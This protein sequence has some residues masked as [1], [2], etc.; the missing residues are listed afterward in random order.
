MLSQRI[1][2]ILTSIANDTY[3]GLIKPFRLEVHAKEM[4]TRHGDYTP[5]T[6]VMRIFNLSR[7]TT[8]I[9]TTSIH[10]LAHHC[11]VCLRDTSDHSKDFY[12]CLRDLL[13]AAIRKGYIDYTTARQVTDAGDIRMLEKYFGD[14]L[15]TYRELNTADG[16]YLAKA[17]K[18]FA[19][20]DTLK[21]RGYRWSE[22]EVAWCREISQHSVEAEQEFLHSLLPPEQ[23]SITRS[24]DAVIEAVYHVVIDGG[25]SIKDQLKARG[26]IYKGYGYTKKSVWVR[27]IP[28]QGLAEEK[29]FL[30]GVGCTEYKVEG[31]KTGE[32]GDKK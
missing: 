32:K 2:T 8:Y 5:S 25:Y 22:L 3:P 1:H 15:T 26:Y 14:V 6:A 30:A 18:A 4:K 19:V 11:D 24:Q 20:K 27:R 13:A 17:L 12:A 9:I 28:A 7:P 31:K 21:A 16:T 29:G 23:V 10:E